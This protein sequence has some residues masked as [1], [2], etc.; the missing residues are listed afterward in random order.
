MKIKGLTIE[1]C[2]DINYFQLLTTKGMRLNNPK[3]GATGI[4]S[5]LSKII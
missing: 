1:K 4:F 5:V 2:Y 3:S